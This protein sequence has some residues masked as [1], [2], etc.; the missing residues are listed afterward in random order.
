MITKNLL[1][2][3]EEIDFTYIENKDNA[4]SH[5]YAIYGGY[6]VT[7]YEAAGKKVAYLNFKF[8]DNEE[9]ALKRYDM[10][11]EFSSEIVE[12][13]VS[14]YSISED[15]MRVYST[16]NVPT[17]LKLIDY[18]VSLLKDYEIRGVEYCS[19]CG[20][21]FGSRNPKKVYFNCEN[22]LMCEHCALETVEE[23]NVKSNETVANTNNKIG[24]GIFGSVV[25][26][27]IGSLVYLAL[28]YFLS[29]AISE[30]GL[31][32]AKYIFCAVGGLVAF[33]AYFGYRL[34]NKS[35]TVASYVTVGINSL[36]FTAIGQYIGV[37]FEF[38]KKN[39]YTLS[40]LKNK[41]FWLLHIRNTVPAEVAAQFTDYSGIFYKTLIISAMFAVVG[42]AIFILT[43][44]DKANVKKET[45]QIE[46]IVLN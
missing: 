15:G 36:L 25:F 1:K 45:A 5:A 27:F 35:V 26:S 31:T 37:V 10:S 46:T 23:T 4:K 21:K 24:L 33:L 7:V 42:A 43:L 14:D 19:K 13:A 38:I 8:P 22:R 12:Y 16:A 34:F 6:L 40:A 18:C 28:Y 17:F 29:P 44:H 20:N 30:S 41:H 39:G 32:D 9:N 11:E 2:A 3:L